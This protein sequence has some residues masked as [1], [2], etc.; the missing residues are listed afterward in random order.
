LTGHHGNNALKKILEK[1]SGRCLLAVGAGLLLSAAFPNFN[2]AGFAWAAP[3]LMLA[4]AA[5][6]TGAESF[7]IGYVAG[8]SFWLASLCWLLHMPV[9][10]F[11]ILGWVALCAFLALFSA[12]WVWLVAECGMRSAEC[13]PWTQRTAWSLTGAAAW[14]ALEM[15]RARIFSGFPWN[16]IGIS[17]FKLVPLIQ[18]ASVTGVYGVSFLVVWFS[19]ALFSAAQMIFRHPARRHVWQAEIVFPLV[20]IMLL[21]VL[22]MAQADRE[23]SSGAILRVTLVQPSIPQTLIW[24][25]DADDER[26]QQ[27]LA[28]NQAAL[29]HETDLLVW[30]ESA[31]PDMNEENCR[32]ISSL[33]RMHHVWIIVNGEDSETRPEATNYFNAAFLI[34][35][36]GRLMS[37]YHKRQLVIFGEYVPLARWLPFV[38]WFTPITGGFTPGDR[39]A[40]FE[41]TGLDGSPRGP[42][43]ATN[44]ISLGGSPV[45]SHRRVKTSPLICFEDIFP[46][47]A[48]GAADDDTDFLVNLTNDGWFGKSAE[49][50]QHAAAAIFRAV[51]NGLPLVRCANN[52]VT[53]WIDAH[54]RIQKV[55]TDQTGDVHGPGAMTVEIPVGENRAPTFY[56]RHGDWFGWACVAITLAL[57]GK[58]IIPRRQITAGQKI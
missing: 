45:A 43:G 13:G 14:V 5:G 33:A 49:Q 29:T 16:F 54:G 56:H 48:R 26:F 50:W 41:I 23:N 9:T 31:V 24:N 30:P 11:P 28:Q 44:V 20:V 27:F 57:I 34:N 4:C 17:Q 12:V 1:M 36:D 38:K 25:P 8:L 2:L 51:E 42:F 10:G 55:L 32:L 22:G 15:L 37:V 6:K 47:T 46:G 19:L 7:C 21:F 58:R 35:P 40:Q 39:P 52:G 3:A 18:I 53:C